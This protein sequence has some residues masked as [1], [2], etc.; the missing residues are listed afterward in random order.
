MRYVIVSS[1]LVLFVFHLARDV[2]HNPHI[3]TADQPHYSSI[4]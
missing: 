3:A 4:R 2:M 1:S